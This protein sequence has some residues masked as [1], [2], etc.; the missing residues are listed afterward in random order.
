M[1]DSDVLNEIHTLI[2]FGFPMGD[3]VAVI[4]YVFPLLLLSIILLLYQ[5]YMIPDE[6]RRNLLVFIGIFSFTIATL[7]LLYSAFGAMWWGLD[8]LTFGSWY[9]FIAALQGLTNLIF[10]SVFGSLAYIIGI[11]IG[12][13]VLANLVIAPPDPDFVGLRAELKEAEDNIKE[14]ESDVK[15]LAEEKNKLEAEN[16]KLNEFLSEREES[17][18]KLQTQVESLTTEVESLKSEEGEPVEKVPLEQLETLRM[19]LD[20]ARSEAEA[21]KTQEQELLETV[22]RKDQTISTL[23]SEL[24]EAKS[25]K[26]PDSEATPP[27]SD[28]VVKSLKEQ[29][30]SCKE[31]LENYAR[32]AETATEVSDSVISDLVHLISQI[33]SSQLDASSKEVLT[34]LVEGLGRSVGRVSGPPGEK[35]KDEPKIEMIGAVMMVHEI[36]DGVKKLT[37]K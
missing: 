7:L 22:S 2:D 33:E 3:I 17:L 36:V 34:D 24:A 6:I 23:Q 5:R 15:S 18:K 16:K 14:L 20:Q 4:P 12:F 25:T 26:T 27:V 28:E 8:E 10:G 35:E 19:E 9:P 32:R 13:F 11:G 37:R 29:L 21:A 31:K 1:L 30:Q